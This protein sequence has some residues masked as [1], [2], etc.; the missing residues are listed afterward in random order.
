MKPQRFMAVLLTCS[1]VAGLSW[2]AW[3]GPWG[4]S[5]NF[6]R[7]KFTLIGAARITNPAYHVQNENMYSSCHSVHG[8]IDK[9]RTIQVA[10]Q[11]IGYDE[12][13]AWLYQNVSFELRLDGTIVHP[14]LEETY[15]S[16]VISTPDAFRDVSVK[17]VKELLE[18]D[19]RADYRLLIGFK[20]GIAWDRYV[21]LVESSSYDGR[22]S[23]SNVVFFSPFGAA[24][25]ARKGFPGK[26]VPIGWDW[27]KEI[28]EL[29]GRTGGSEGDQLGEFRHWVSMFDPDDDRVLRSFGLNLADLKKRAGQGLVYG[30]VALGRG[31]E[32]LK[33]LESPQV[34]WVR[35]IG[36][37]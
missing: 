16:T 31:T 10:V 18:K 20:G 24:S 8:P 32:H 3:P 5:E 36:R 13:K 14:K 25:N 22:T 29:M 15:L 23:S 35:V 19:S 11:P 2:T 30:Y 4:C 33:L 28:R 26:V 34:S 21:D 37:G 12:R 17:A 9:S 1:A 27:S 7:T 6:D